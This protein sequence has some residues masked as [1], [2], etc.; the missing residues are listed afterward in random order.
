MVA[1]DHCEINQKNSK[2]R[3]SVFCAKY[4]HMMIITNARTH[5]DSEWWRR[6]VYM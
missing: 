6:H 2:E 1:I 3:P 4:F 5:N